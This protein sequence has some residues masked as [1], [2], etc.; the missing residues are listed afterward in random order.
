MR[1]N[2][3]LGRSA[4]FPG[5]GPR[6]PADKPSADSAMIRRRPPVQVYPSRPHR[7][8]RTNRAGTTA[9][10]PEMLLRRCYDPHHRLLEAAVDAAIR[11]QGS[12]LIIDAH[13]FPQHRCHTNPNSIPTAPTSVSEPAMSIRLR[14][15]SSWRRD[16]SANVDFQS[17]GTIH[18]RGRWFR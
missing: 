2:E 1:L 15:S 14:T 12:C 17:Q 3:E 11:E 10:R 7:R 16:I 4:E 9:T 18:M 5:A 8:I 6:D 13:S